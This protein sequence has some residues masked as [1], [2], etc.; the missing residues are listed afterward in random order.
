MP[1]PRRTPWYAVDVDV[2]KDER[3]ADLPSDAARWG[4][5][6]AVL[7]EARLQ[8][9][10]GVFGS[11]AT[12]IE[13]IG[14]FGKHVP[15]YLKGGL[16]EEAPQ[17]CPP[18]L[19]A[20]G[21][22]RSGAIV[23]HNWARKQNDPGHAER[24][25]LY[26]GKG[27]EGDGEGDAHGDAKVTP[28]VTGYSRARAETQ[29]LDT[30]IG[31]SPS[32]SPPSDRPDVVALVQLHRWRRVTKAQRGIL[33]ELASFERLSEADVASGY[34]VVAAW[35]RETPDGEDPLQYAMACGKRRRADRQLTAA[36]ADTQWRAEKAAD[37]STAPE[38]LG[39][40]VD[41]VN[42]HAQ[43]QAQEATTVEPAPAPTARPRSASNG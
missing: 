38:R 24:Q 9:Q 31:E 21:A 29:T 40:I 27:R 41:R 32:V 35:I 12:L 6:G 11:R 2:R 8:T 1:T 3:I 39:A 13:A 33:E 42:G 7:A 34:A 43:A 15:D 4:Y 28:M 17:L 22:Q 23:V 26:R 14:R 18:C 20:F 30:D 10:R 25:E 19:Q 16:L 36:Q 37:R 5:V